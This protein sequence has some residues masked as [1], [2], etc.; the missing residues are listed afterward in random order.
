MKLSTQVTTH[1]RREKYYTLL[2]TRGGVR[3][4]WTG[5]EGMGGRSKYFLL[6]NKNYYKIITRKLP[7]NSYSNIT[8]QLL[9]AHYYTTTTQLLHE[10]HNEVIVWTGQVTKAGECFWLGTLAGMEWEL[11]D[12][13]EPTAGVELYYFDGEQV[14]LTECIHQL[15]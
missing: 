11:I 12:D 14:F 3:L 10:P 2:E 6:A 1:L 15:L 9:L 7:H 13:A 8:T 4:K 5:D